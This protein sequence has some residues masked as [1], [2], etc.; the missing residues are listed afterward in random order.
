MT[1]FSLATKAFIV[2]DEKVLII[3]RRSNDVHCA[4]VWDLPGGRIGPEEDPVDGIKRET[5]EETGLEIEVILPI[6]TKHFTRDDGQVVTGITFLCEPK[7]KNA[8]ITLSEEHTEYKWEEVGKARGIVYPGFLNVFD[9]YEKIRSG[10]LF[11]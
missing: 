2:E 1:N 5:R 4:G 6:G 7:H 11:R 9:A 3:K 8:K 10:K